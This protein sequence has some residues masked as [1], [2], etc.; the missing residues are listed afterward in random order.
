[1][2]S[3]SMILLVIIFFTLTL[4]H[5]TPTIGQPVRSRSSLDDRSRKTPSYQNDR[6]RRE[7]NQRKPYNRDDR[8][9]K[10]SYHRDERQTKYESARKGKYEIKY[11][12]SYNRDRLRKSSYRLHRL[13]KGNNSDKDSYAAKF[14]SNAVDSFAATIGRKRR[15]RSSMEAAERQDRMTN[16][17]YEL[18]QIARKNLESSEKELKRLHKD[19]AQFTISRVEADKAEVPKGHT[20]RNAWADKFVELEKAKSNVR[21]HETAGNYLQHVPGVSQALHEQADRLKNGANRLES[22]MVKL[23]SEGSHDEDLKDDH[24]GKE[25]LKKWNYDKKVENYKHLIAL[26]KSMISRQGKPVKL[27]RAIPL[28]PTILGMKS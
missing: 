20:N 12:D 28:F 14:R 1:M 26:D 13:Q 2:T 4:T 21:R 10:K 24:H 25:Y 22:E 27:G 23:K 5:L 3:N 9:G 17:E 7:P 8:L 16:Y 6:S 18:V 15:D 11:Q 19:H